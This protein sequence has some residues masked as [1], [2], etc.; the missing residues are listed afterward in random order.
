MREDVNMSNL[1]GMEWSAS[2]ISTGIVSNTF[3]TYKSR[4][5]LAITSEYL[6][7]N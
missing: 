4:V 7:L 5:A 3:R 2:L 6:S 1:T